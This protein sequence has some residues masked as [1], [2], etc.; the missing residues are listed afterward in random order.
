[1]QQSPLGVRPLADAAAVSAA[2]KAIY[3]NFSGP[4][5]QEVIVSRGKV[6]E[7]LRPDESGKMQTI[8]ATEVFGQIR[9]LVPFRLTGGNRDYI[10][11]G[12]DSGRIVILEYS[13]EKNSFI[14]VSLPS[15]GTASCECASTGLTRH[16]DLL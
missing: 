9:S 13:K 11:V 12:S 2:Q 1:M 7:L 14:K 16:R 15:A 8:V 6:L 5:A 4:K 3:G 10:V